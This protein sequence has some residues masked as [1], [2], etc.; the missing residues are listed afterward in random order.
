[1]SPSRTKRRH[2][3]RRSQ[4]EKRWLPPI[5]ITTAPVVSDAKGTPENLDGA[6]AQALRAALAAPA[7]VSSSVER[8]SVV[9]RV[10]SVETNMPPTRARI[11]SEQPHPEC[12]V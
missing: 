7:T 11:Q 3:K 8:S 1:V 4:P 9:G 10:T 5:D 12:A 2:L 6:L